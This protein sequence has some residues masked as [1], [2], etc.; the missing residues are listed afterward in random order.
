MA[1]KPTIYKFNIALSD[2][3]RNYYDTLH[4][5]V[6]Q[7]PSENSERMMTRVLAFCLNAQENLTFTKGLSAIEEPDLWI[8]SLDDQL[9]LWVDIGEPAVDRVKKAT[10]LAR[11]T[12][13]YS[14]NSKSTVWWEQNKNKLQRLNVSIYQFQWQ[15]IQS[16]ASL[17]ERTMECSVT[18][19]GNSAY[20]A[21]AL[22]ECEIPW[23]ELKS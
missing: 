19:T 20:I 15:D 16:L 14:F 1:L 2:L 6:A 9:L 23:H 7:H 10:R 4:L 13:V 17:V 5:T 18:I 3:N 8:R 12:K 22:G 11:A 21:T